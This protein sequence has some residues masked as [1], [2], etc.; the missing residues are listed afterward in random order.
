M[1]DAVGPTPPDPRAAG[2]QLPGAHARRAPR[3]QHRRSRARPRTSS[4]SRWCART[5][6]SPSPACSTRLLLT[7]HDELLFE[8]PPAEQDAARELIER[9]M[10]GVWEQ[11]AAARG[12]RRRRTELAGGQVSRGLAVAARRRRGVPG[13]HAGAD[14]LAAGQVS[15][16]PQAASFSF[17]VGTVALV[18]IPLSRAAASAA[19]A[20]IGARALVGA[21]RRPARRRLR[22]R[23]AGGGAHARRQR[24]DRRRDRRPAGRSRS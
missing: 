14:Q 6:R 9:E 11:R 16:A 18:A 21:R 3:R 20:S 13:R 2:A 12:R 24:A 5:P 10:C 8:G 19:S 1:H 15:A 7:I 23:R 4:S 22:E 17:L